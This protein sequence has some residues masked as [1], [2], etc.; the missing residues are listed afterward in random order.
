MI[1]LGVD[2][3][4][5]IA[6]VA[7]LEVTGATTRAIHLGEVRLPAK[8][9]LEQRLYK[10]FEAIC[11]LIEQYKPEIVVLEDTFFA[12]NVKTAFV[13][14]Q[15]R[16]AAMM[17]AARYSLPVRLYPPAEVKKAVAGVGG[18]TKTQ[19]AFMIRHLLDWRA[20]LTSPDAADAAAVALCHAHRAKLEKQST[21]PRVRESASP[22]AKTKHKN[23]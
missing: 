22:K 6:G 20:P 16:G 23:D 21:S 7:V 5:Q 4:S 18:A 11:A 9:P 8:A 1:I 17:A 15:S 10:L 19:V 2:P 13:I 12:V 3:G 14:G